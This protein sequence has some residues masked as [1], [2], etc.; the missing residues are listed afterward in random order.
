MSLPARWKT[1]WFARC[2]VLFFLISGFLNCAS[3]CAAQE[4]VQQDGPI[5]IY[6]KNR[7]Q[8]INEQ[9]KVHQAFKAQADA[10]NQEIT[11]LKQGIEQKSQELNRVEANITRNSAGISTLAVLQSGASLFLFPLLSLYSQVVSVFSGQGQSILPLIFLS[12]TV[13]NIFLYLLFKQKPFFQRHKLFLIVAVVLLI[14]SIASPLFA[15]EKDKREEVVSKLKIAEEMLSRSDHQRFIEILE[16]KPTQRIQVPP[17]QSGDPLFK[18]H[19]EVTVGS[20]E[21][22]STLAALY[23]HENMKRKAL[24]A[25][26]K[27]TQESWLQETAE[28]Q[29]ILINSIKYLIQNQQTEDVMAS[30]DSLSGTITDVNTLLSM[31][32]LLKENGMQGSSE[33]ILGYAILKANTVQD[34]MG[35]SKYFQEK[36]EFDKSNEALEKAVGRVQNSDEILLLAKAAMNVKKD[37]L[38]GKITQAMHEGTTDYQAKMQL[39]DLL[40]DNGRKEEAVD[41]VSKIIKEDTSRSQENVDKLL[42]LIN[43]ALKRNML[44]Q[45]TTAS[46]TLIAMLGLQ[47]AM[48]TPVQT[49]TKLKSIEGVPDEGKIRLPHFYGLVNE[50]QGFSDKAEEAYIQSVLGSLA[51]IIDSYGYK[52]PESRNDFYL[53][54]RTWSKGNRSE[55]IGHLDKVYGFIEKDYIAKQSAEN[56]KQLQVLQEEIQ[57]LKNQSQELDQALVAANKKSTSVFTKLVVQAISTTATIIFLVAVLIG[58]I[59]L[60][61]RYSRRLSVGKTFGFSMKFCE[62]AGWLQVLS[63]LGA[64]NGLATVFVAQFFLIFQMVQE[65]T[66]QTAAGLPPLPATVNLSEPANVEEHEPVTNA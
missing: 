65:N 28:H 47:Q 16:K 40:L 57:A 53:L 34:L 66:R 44:P 31:A 4:Q 9:Q 30:I 20:P 23:T 1:L 27:I 58:I 25:V 21:Y 50:E 43:A 6:Q 14:G 63:I 22:W 5:A 36:N 24:D 48:D 13:L 17:L 11:G 45:A 59:V 51:T 52:F 61:Y 39:V 60:S 46:E 32:V 7:Q 3:W 64:L 12:L 29:E 62:T 15:D 35:L 26:K 37:G 18:V 49:E 2:T 19:P 54:G 8:Y 38:L 10:L 33:K 41:L 42:F 55:F 56:D